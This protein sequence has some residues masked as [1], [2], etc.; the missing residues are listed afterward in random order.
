MIWNTYSAMASAL[1]LASSGDNKSGATKIYNECDWYIVVFFYDSVV[2]VGMQ[3]AFHQLTA[4]WASKYNGSVMQALARVGNYD[5]KDGIRSSS[6]GGLRIWG[7]QVAHY[8]ACAV[9]VRVVS[10]GAL[11]GF[12][13]QMQAV[14]TYIG[15]WACT[16]KQITL[17]VWL[18]IVI[19]YSTRTSSLLFS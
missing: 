1:A 2:S 4:Q 7:W 8:T 13:T 3:I 9:A 10:F 18:N 5:E 11:Y 19:L 15:W 14:A 16:E 12:R 17:K 6:S